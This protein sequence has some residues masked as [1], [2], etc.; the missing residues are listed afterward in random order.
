[1]FAF[2]RSGGVP[3]WIVILFG[4]L[5]LAAAATLIIRPDQGRVAQIRALC[6]A[7]LYATLA[8]VTSC[9][10]AVM[11]NVPAHPEWWA[12]G[13]IHLAVMTGLGES[14]S[15]GILGFSFIGLAWLATAVGLRRLAAE[16]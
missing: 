13:K 15:C 8:G 1:M 10:A 2:I 9:L 6:R 3:I 14:L 12:G 5:T 7:T 11:H 4:L 16:L